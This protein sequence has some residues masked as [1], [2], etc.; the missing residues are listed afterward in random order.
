MGSISPEYPFVGRAIDIRQSN[1]QLDLKGAILEGLNKRPQELPAVLMWDDKGSEIYE[2]LCE[3]P[4]YYPRS[5]ET[6]ILQRYCADM[7][8]TFSASSILIELGCG[9]LQKTS[10]ILAALEAQKKQVLY[11]AVDISVDTLNRSLLDL[12]NRFCSSPTIRVTGLLG[13]YADCVEWVKSSFHSFSTPN[14]TF[15][16]MGNTIA[17]T[18]IEE[19]ASML[20]S[21]RQACGGNCSFI[22]GADTCSDISRIFGAYDYRPGPLHDIVANGMHAANRAIGHKVFKLED[23]KVRVWQGTKI[24]QLLS[25]K[26]SNEQ[27]AF[28]SQLGGFTLTDSWIHSEGIYGFYRICAESPGA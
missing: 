11:Y 20:A 1:E 3:D 7:A 10:A 22:F 16:W 21:F 6:E 17:N 28:M 23:W 26:W 2:R 18:E 9:N 13:T 19:A 8:D 24:N 27:I 14:I 25:G 5:C 12:S 4:A 15:L